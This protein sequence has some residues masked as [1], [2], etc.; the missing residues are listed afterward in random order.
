MIGVSASTACSGDLFLSSL[1]SS[2]TVF[3]HAQFSQNQISVCSLL[4]RRT[5]EFSCW[6]SWESERVRLC[7]RVAFLTLGNLILKHSAS[8]FGNLIKQEVQFSMIF[9]RQ[10]I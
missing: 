10:N 1:T 2:I 6:F 9:F 8:Q 4:H 5:T 7:S 3:Y